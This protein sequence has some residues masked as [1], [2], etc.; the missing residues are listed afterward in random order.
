MVVVVVVV[1]VVVAIVVFSSSS[2]I[3]LHKLQVREVTVS[4]TISAALDT[5]I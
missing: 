5:D 3:F 4:G 2:E 1:V